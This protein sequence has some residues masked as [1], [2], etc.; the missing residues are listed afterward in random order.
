[1]V[2]L[3]NKKTLKIIFISVIILVSVLVS[4]LLFSYFSKEKE[5]NHL[6]KYK[7]N[8]YIP[9]HVSYEDLAKIYL[10]DYAYYMSFD[11]KTAYELLDTKYR[12]KKFNSISDFSSYINNL[13]NQKIRMK[14]YIKY[15]IG[16]YTIFKVYD[17]N[18]NLFVFKTNGVM[19]Y[20]VYLDD[21][22]VEVGD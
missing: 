13:R 21:S 19:Q 17:E 10:N 14:K 22:T 3:M 5:Y 4:C 20:R 2:I 15:S 16:K 11:T 8:E 1:M 12:E 18:D 6:R 9:T 7:V